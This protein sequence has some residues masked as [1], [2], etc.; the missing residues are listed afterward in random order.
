MNLNLKSYLDKRAN[1]R[2]DEFQFEYHA[3]NVSKQYDTIC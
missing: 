3:K 2:S 1:F